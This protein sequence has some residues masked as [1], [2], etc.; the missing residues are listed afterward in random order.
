MQAC[1]FCRIVRGED[2]DAVVVWEDDL[3][4]AFAPLEP[5]T[6]GHTLVVP[7][8][9]V[10]RVWDMS[11]ADAAAVMSTTVALS[12]SLR[13]V[14]QPDGLN[15]IQSNGAAATQTVDHVHVHL[16]PRWSRDRMTLRWPKTGAQT[17]AQQR[18]TA[19]H[20]R[21][22]LERWGTTSLPASSPEDRRQHLSFIQSVISRMASASA[23]AKTWLLPIATAAYG[24][25]FVQHSWPIAALG[26]AA[27]AVFALLDA[28]YLKQERSFRD[29]Y[30]HVAK[31][32]AVPPFSMNP[33]V[34]GP[35]DRAK[36]NYWPDWQ[37]WQS[38]AI[39]PFY[40]PL[41]LAGGVLIGYIAVSC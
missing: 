1:A 12:R 4:V 36:V 31:G 40:L 41:L 39:A 20:V 22:D 24:Y 8:T 6:R 11:E 3:T 19:L 5:A 26:M 15:V 37:D 34:A 21:D 33:T 17:R 7:K 27:V 38:W 29:L 9:H 10:A 25:G 18:V 14:L 30:D 2:A 16:V 23:S 35:S 13:Q 32:G 28:N